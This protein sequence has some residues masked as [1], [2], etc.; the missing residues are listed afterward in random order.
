MGISQVGK[1]SDFDS[2]M[3]RFESCIP[4]HKEKHMSHTLLNEYNIN[5]CYDYCTGNTK[6]FESLDENYINLLLTYVTDKNSSTIREAITC[7][8]A[9]Y[10]WLTE[11][12]GMDAIDEKTGKLKEIK[13][14]TNYA[15]NSPSS[16]GGNFNDFRL[17]RHQKYLNENYDILCS[18][19]SHHRL[20][21]VVEFPY[22][23]IASHI[24]KNILRVMENQ[25][26]GNNTRC[27]PSFSYS[28]YINYPNLIV[29][30][31]DS[32]TARMYNAIN[33]KHIEVLEIINSQTNDITQF[34]ES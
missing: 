27:S 12:H 11:K 24:E 9:G 6:S 3:H 17:E 2:D 25:V 33:R 15:E 29:H 26:K 10:K 18:M 20:I 16:G 30:Y 13:P 31:L 8:A 7:K 32:R 34:F 21:Y 28:D 14:T 1:A 19:F 23:V 22:S 4:Y 5:I